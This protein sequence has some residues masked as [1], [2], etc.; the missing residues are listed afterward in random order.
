MED[1][2]F[3]RLFLSFVS[4]LSLPCDLRF[5]SSKKRTLLGYADPRQRGQKEEWGGGRER[6]EIQEE[7]KNSQFAN[8][9]YLNVG[10]TCPGHCEENVFTS[11]IFMSA[12]VPRYIRQG[13]ESS[14]RHVSTL[15]SGYVHRH[16][17]KNA[18]N[19]LPR[20]TEAT[21]RNAT[22]IG[23]GLVRIGKLEDAPPPSGNVTLGVNV[24]A[25]ENTVS[26]CSK[27]A[28]HNGT[29]DAKPARIA[30]SLRFFKNANFYFLLICSV[31]LIANN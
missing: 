12:N 13:N 25:F 31:K 21:Q 14:R 24:G 17:P 8:R 15:A 10:K 19:A 27:I 6:K 9:N 29:A 7:R 23:I 28:I 2:F 4:P 22:A 18:P 20:H 16:T 11:M 30:I 26:A 3:L 1:E 5:R